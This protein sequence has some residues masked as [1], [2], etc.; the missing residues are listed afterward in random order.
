MLTGRTDAVPCIATTCKELQQ[1]I[2]EIILG[3]LDKNWHHQNLSLPVPPAT[4]PTKAEISNP[5]VTRLELPLDVDK[6]IAEFLDDMLAKFKVP[7]TSTKDQDNGNTDSDSNS[8]SDLETA[9]VDTNGQH[10]IDLDEIEVELLLDIES[11]DGYEAYLEFGEDHLALDDNIAMSPTPDT[12]MM[13]IGQTNKDLQMD[14]L[15]MPGACL[16]QCLNRLEHLHQQKVHAAMLLA[17]PFAD[18]LKFQFVQWLVKNDVSQGAQDKLIKL[19]IITQRAGLSFSSNHTLN[20]L[21]DKLPTAG[22]KWRR[23]TQKITGN[24]TGANGKKLTELVEI[25]MRNILQVVEELL[26]NIAYGKQLVF[27]PQ[28]VYLDDGKRKI[29]EMWTADWWNETQKKLPPGATVIPIIISSDATQ[30]T[31]FLGGKSAWPVYITIGNIPQSIRA[32]V[33]SY[34]TMLLAYLPSPKFNCFTKKERGNQE[35]QTN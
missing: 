26:G 16:R 11:K 29:D 10:N 13:D 5:D 1:Q 12:D 27:V 31:N 17:W 33:S 20:K 30:L 19:P 24:I 21:L 2:Q 7:P 32:K 9:S 4:S 6:R 22:P 18:Y 8:K 14:E 23:I 15:D 3:I 28:K 35:S 25:W 34:A